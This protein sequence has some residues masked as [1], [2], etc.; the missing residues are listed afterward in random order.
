ML[1]SLQHGVCLSTCL[2]HAVS[3]CLDVYNTGVLCHVG[4]P[5]KHATPNELVYITWTV[6]QRDKVKP[7][8]GW[9]GR[10]C[11]YWLQPRVQCPLARAVD[12]PHSAAAPLHGSCQSTATS[13]I[14]KRAVLVLPCKLRYVRIRPLPLP[15][16]LYSMVPYPVSFLEWL[17][18]PTS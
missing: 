7:W 17:L 8:C 3:A 4:W 1:H 2:Q 9:L 12:R 13:E 14:V 10:W 5:T 6:Q 15:S 18:T 16:D 11:A